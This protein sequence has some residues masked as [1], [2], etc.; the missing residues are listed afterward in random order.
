MSPQTQASRPSRNPQRQLPLFRAAGLVFGSSPIDHLIGEFRQARNAVQGWHD[1]DAAARAKLGQV[2][3]HNAKWRRKSQSEAFQALNRV[4]A[5]M[6]A[7]YR[8]LEALKA[9][10]LALGVSPE[11]V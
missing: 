10:L 3:R 11:V 8:A 2:N 4:R 7:N 5:G 9:A 6:R 1:M